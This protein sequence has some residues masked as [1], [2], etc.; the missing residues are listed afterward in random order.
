VRWHGR[1]EPWGD[2]GRGCGNVLKASTAGAGITAR[3]VSV[4]G[5]EKGESELICES[6]RINPQ[7]VQ[8]NRLRE[9]G[10]QGDRDRHQV[11]PTR[12]AP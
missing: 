5:W 10:R 6:H 7:Y 11:A 8:V 9:D 1:Q 3:I 2:G 12:T 4:A